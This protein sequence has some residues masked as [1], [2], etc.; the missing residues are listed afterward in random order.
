M[1]R[2]RFSYFVAGCALVALGLASRRYGDWLPK[3]LASY[4]GDTL[5]AL[6]VFVGIGFLAPRWS[7][8]RVSVAALLFSCTVEFSQLYH[9]PWLDSLRHRRVGGLILGVG[10]L[11]SDLLCYTIGVAIGLLIEMMIYPRKDKA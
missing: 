2:C 3:F 8:L 9:A 5:W 4:S 1:R 6:M 7:S 11:W 10:F